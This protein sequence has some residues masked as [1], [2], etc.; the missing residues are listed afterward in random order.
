ML[1]AYR[2]WCT[3]LI[4]WFHRI[5]NETIILTMLN[6]A[7]CWPC[8]ILPDA[9]HAQ[10]CLM[11]TMLNTAWCWPCSILPDADHAQYCLMLTMLN[12]AWCWPCSILPDAGRFFSSVELA[13]VALI[14][15]L[16]WLHYLAIYLRLW[17]HYLNYICSMSLTTLASIHQYIH[18]S[19]LNINNTATH[20]LTCN[21]I[22]NNITCNI[23]KWF[24]IIHSLTD[25]L[26]YCACVL[27]R[28][29]SKYIL[30]LLTKYILALL[31]LLCRVAPANTF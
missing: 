26:T 8:S 3:D 28:C 14:F 4:E 18:T 10:Y 9:G 13:L 7:W 6:T 16:S 1:L 22:N 24:F 11:L 21:M 29:A 5:G 25:L 17:L 30:T 23:I 27:S 2:Q 12:T 15:I 19:I 20:T 31:L